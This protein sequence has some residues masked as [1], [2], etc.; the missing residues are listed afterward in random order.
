[1]STAAYN[2]KVRIARVWDPV[3]EGKT[4]GDGKYTEANGYKAANDALVGTRMGEWCELPTDSPSLNF[5]AELIDDTELKNNDGYRSRLFG[6]HDW[7][8]N[9]DSMFESGDPGLICIRTALLARRNI[10]A[11]YLPNG[12]GALSDGLQGVC[13]VENYNF[14][15]AVSGD[16]KI[17]ITLQGSGNLSV[18][19][20]NG[21]AT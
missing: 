11:Q 5:G 19:T 17:G 13:K 15:G 10:I 7:S 3:P 6:L 1:M 21:K 12:V 16:E 20:D 14:G 18:A 2:K 8:M 9:V 4:L